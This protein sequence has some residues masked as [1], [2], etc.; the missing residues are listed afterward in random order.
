MVSDTPHIVIFSHGFGVRKEDRG[1]FTAIAN[2]LP[3]V[4]SVLFNYHPINEASNTLAATPLDKQVRKLRKVINAARIEYPGAVIDLVCHSQ[5]CIAA[6]LLK[7]RYI[8]K[9]IMITPPD[10]VREA[11]VTRQ[12][13]A[14]SEMAID[15][16]TRT[17]LL[18][19]DGSTTVIHPEYWQS[20][21]GIEPTK[22]YNRLA[23]FT[24]LRII[25]ARQDEVLGDVS[26]E[27]IDPSISL[28]TLDGNHNFEGEDSRN[29]LLYIMRKELTLEPAKRQG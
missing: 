27:G 17:R 20:L 13:S 25:N 21:V 15:T 19:S 14:R 10:D 7:P 26:L 22:L 1:L 28:V 12:L 6:A 23:R 18:R 8:R 2:A 3:E 9:I 4:R 29:R 24:T 16:S 11:T 5:G